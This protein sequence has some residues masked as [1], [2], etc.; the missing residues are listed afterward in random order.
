MDPPIY[1]PTP[2]N[3]LKKRKHQDSILSKENSRLMETVNL[4]NNSHSDLPSYQPTPIDE[5]NGL[6]SPHPYYSELKKADLSNSFR[7]DNFPA[8]SPT[9]IEDSLA[10]DLIRPTELPTYS[11][12]VRRD[13]PLYP[14][15]TARDVLCQP[16]PAYP[17][18]LKRTHSPE[19]SISSHSVN[20]GLSSSMISAKL[21]SFV[22]KAAS[23]E[24]QARESQLKRSLKVSVSIPVIDTPD[25][26]VPA[27]PFLNSSAKTRSPIPDP[28]APNILPTFDPTSMQTSSPKDPPSPL[29]LQITETVRSDEAKQLNK[30]K[31]R[32]SA[33]LRK[34]EKLLSLYRDLYNEELGTTETNES[35]KEDYAELPDKIITKSESSK[36][37]GKHIKLDEVGGVLSETSIHRQRKQESTIRPYRAAILDRAEKLFLARSQVGF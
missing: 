33:K 2:I 19:C 20:S 28:V 6:A 21:Q 4:P 1:K 18:E 10:S 23:I 26:A 35:L 11:P 37:Q 17:P 36:V 8:Y 5:L 30:R 31:D 16:S 25:F 7:K 27:I 14:V 15:F 29:T 12:V 3:Q 32:E 13:T 24:A 9:V 34:R 22:Q